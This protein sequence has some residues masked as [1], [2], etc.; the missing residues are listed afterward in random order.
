MS[1]PYLA[2]SFI[3]S[4]GFGKSLKNETTIIILLN[5]RLRLTRSFIYV[6]RTVGKGVLEPK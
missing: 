6:A 5:K 3:N 1:R 2:V 4:L